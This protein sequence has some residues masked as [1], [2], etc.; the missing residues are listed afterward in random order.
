M[1]GEGDTYDRYHQ[2]Y[3]ENTRKFVANV[4]EDLRELAGNTEIPFIDAQ[5]A[6]GNWTYWSQ[7]N[8]AKRTFSQE[9]GNNYL[10]QSIQEGLHTD[11]EPTGSVDLAHF[12]SD[13]E[14]KLGRLFAQNFEQ[15]LELPEEVGE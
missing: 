14:V 7:V 6:P 11:Q 5:I 13:S 4:R 10:I 9:S 3:L 1:Q 8:A 12:D 15:F 2:Y